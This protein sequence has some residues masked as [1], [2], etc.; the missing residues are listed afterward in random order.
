MTLSQSQHFF[1]LVND[2]VMTR[3]MDGIINFWNRSAEELYG[4]RKEEAVGRV[5]HDLLR[6]QFP[7]PLEEIES[8]VVRNGRWEGKLVHT[9]RE[10]GRVVVESRWTL[11]LEG[12]LGALVEINTRSSHP[13][14]RT[15]ANITERKQSE[16]LAKQAATVSQPE[17]VFEL[18]NDSVMT[19][20]MEGRINFWNRSAEELYGWRKEEAVGRVSH[21]LLRT[22]FPKP[23]EEIESE[24]VRN[25]R[26]EGKL[27]HTTREGGRVVVESRW[28]LELEG[29]LGALVEINTRFADAEAYTNTDSAEIGR[30]EPVPT[31]KMKADDLLPKIATIVLAGGAFLSIFVSLYFIYYYGWTGQR[32]FSTP[33]GMVLY[34]VFPAVLAALLFG[35]VRQRPEFKVNLTIFCLSFAASLYGAETFLQLLDQPKPIWLFLQRASKE[36]KPKVAAKIAQEFGVKFDTRDRLEVIADLRKQGIDAVPA[37]LPRDFLRAKEDKE[38][39]EPSDLP[40]LMHRGMRSVIDIHGEEVI[41]LGGV[42]NKVTVVCNESG[43]WITYMSDEHGFNNPTGSWRSGQIDVAALGDSFTQGY[44]VPPENSFVGLIRQA[45][46]ATLNLGMAANGPLYMLATLQEYLPFY[47]PKVV[48]WFYYEGNDLTELQIEKNSGLLMGYLRNGL[49]QGLLRRQNDIDQALTDYI[50]REAA[51]KAS[52][53]AT[54]PDR[55]SKLLEIVKMSTLRNRLGLVYGETA[56]ESVL[57][58]EVQ[59]G[60]GMDLFREVLSR[61]KADVSGW[62]GTLYFVY[63]PGWGR[64]GGEPEIGARQREQVLTS[65]KNLGI[66]I[67]DIYS[68]FEAQGDPMPFFPFR[69]PGHYNEKGHRVVGTEVVKTISSQ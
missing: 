3:T 51:K 29:Q 38:I 34:V 40:V 43:P 25:G 30:Q 14:A 13:Q 17:H 61:A 23:L 27:V 41:P 15:N 54:T 26:W 22:Q 47:R 50:E 8:E 48:L 57:S 53:Q 9:T 62:G 20:S 42:A 19:R 36:E 39:R 31:N 67:I 18:V 58:S 28:T 7:K 60:A 4:W 37:I 68:A 64:Y 2:S 16:N 24:L 5:S 21:D 59:Q 49:T 69:G 1:E 65:V 44:C 32:H 33:F 11:E 6:T 55:V 10:G 66:P 63:L 35:F 52:Q 46:P 12:Q 56:E 45:Y